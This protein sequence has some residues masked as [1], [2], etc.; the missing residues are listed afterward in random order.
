MSECDEVMLN[1]SSF[2]NVSGLIFSEIES[3]DSSRNKSIQFHLIDHTVTL[4][5]SSLF[6]FNIFGSLDSGI[7]GKSENSL[8]F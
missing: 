3:K 4:F 6:K 1:I 5:E 8:P 2:N 7:G